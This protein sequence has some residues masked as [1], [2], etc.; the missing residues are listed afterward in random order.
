MA[1]YLFI[2]LTS[3]FPND[4]GPIYRETLAG[5]LIAEPYNTFSNLVF[6]FIVIYW[7]YRIFKNPKQHLFLTWVI[8]VIAISYVGG[9]IY[10]AT[11]SHEFWLLLDWVP[12]MLLCGALVIYFVFKI[13]AKWWQRILFVIVILGLSFVVRM[14]PMPESM[15]ISI[16]Y[17]VT[18]TTVLLPIMLYL[19]KT[20]FSNYQSI[21]MVFLIFGLAVYFRS[22]DLT[23]E[24]FPMGTHWLWHFFGGVAVHGLIGYIFRDNLLT[25]SAAKQSAND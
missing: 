7:G 1:S 15:K 22:I 9:T 8:P 25:L 19:V 10:H 12:I 3:N 2:S 13:V 24:I 21:L 5:G 11:R 18:A 16:G 6:L 4:S 20:K 23:Q 17:I 14:S